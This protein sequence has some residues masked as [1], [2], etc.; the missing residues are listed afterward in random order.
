MYGVVRQ[1]FADI[2]KKGRAK[3]AAAA[4]AAQA[5]PSELAEPLEWS[6]DWAAIIDAALPDCI[7][8]FNVTRQ[9][10][11]SDDNAELA[12][13]FGLACPCGHRTLRIHGYPLCDYN[14]TV[15]D[16]LPYLTPMALEC[17]SCGEVTEVFDTKLHGYHSELAKEDGGV[18]SAA[19]RGEGPRTVFTC[20][21][22]AAQDM[23]VSVEFGYRD[24][25]LMEDA[26]ELPAHNYF[27]DFSLTGTCE[28]CGT[29]IE[30]T[31]FDL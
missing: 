2:F 30:V 20:P 14:K 21:S 7:A 23:Q 25:D 12:T 26:P 9:P 6:Q 31:R 29:R 15:E 16:A 8:A 5:A 22:D 1:I 4:Q 13:I 3:N 19:I 18:G 11:R 17:A 10:S 24:F 28:K 27:H